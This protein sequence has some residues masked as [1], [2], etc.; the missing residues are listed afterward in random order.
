M[1]LILFFLIAGL[2]MGYP[3][4]SLAKNRI[5]VRMES[6]DATRSRDDAV[7]LLNEENL[8]RMFEIS[9]QS[10]RA[11][12]GDKKTLRTVVSGKSSQ[13]LLLANILTTLSVPTHFQGFLYVRH[14]SDQDNASATQIAIPIGIAWEEC[15]SNEVAL[16]LLPRTIRGGMIFLN[17]SVQTDGRCAAPLF[18]DVFIESSHGETVFERKGIPLGIHLPREEKVWSIPLLTDKPLRRQSYRVSVQVASRKGFVTKITETK[19]LL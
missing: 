2:S 8:P 10:Q 6:K 12:S 14:V 4:R 7:I 13:R 17:A 1:K 15:S 19:E 3:V 5:S 11:D 18:G 9:Q 16:K